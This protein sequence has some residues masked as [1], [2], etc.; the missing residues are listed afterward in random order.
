[1]MGYFGDFEAWEPGTGEDH[2]GI[3]LSVWLGKLR[4][5]G[6]NGYHTDFEAWEPPTYI[7]RYLGDFK[8]GIIVNSGS[9]VTKH[10]DQT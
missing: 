2:W 3:T 8:G 7:Q 10:R 5:G 4:L 1:M 6:I 9:L